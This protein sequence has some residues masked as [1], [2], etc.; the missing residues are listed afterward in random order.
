M[1]DTSALPPWALT[2]SCPNPHFSNGY[3]TD[4]PITYNVV[5]LAEAARDKPVIDVSMSKLRHNLTE[6]RW[7]NELVPMRVINVMSS[8][9]EMSDDILGH[10]DRI[11]YAELK[12]PIIIDSSYDVLDGTHRLAKQYLLNAVT[13]KCVML[14]RD[15]LKGLGKYC[16]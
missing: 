14:T 16:D 6:S 5:D 7:S 15:D 1:A 2:T 8:G 13:A 11:L 3:C 4:G 9:I 10:S 12:Y